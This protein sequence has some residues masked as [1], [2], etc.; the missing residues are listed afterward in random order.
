ML[1]ARRCCQNS[2]VAGG[3][4]V[5]FNLFQQSGAGAS[6]CSVYW[7]V[8]FISKR[9]LFDFEKPTLQHSPLCSPL[10]RSYTFLTD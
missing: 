4:L 1:T 2:E 8:C 5:M 3:N 10:L 7:T 9:K 6:K